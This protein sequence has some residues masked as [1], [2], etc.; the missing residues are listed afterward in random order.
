LQKFKISEKLKEVKVEKRDLQIFGSIWSGIFLVI[1]LY[2]VWSGGELR[3]W[4][5]SIAIL[6]LA[7]SLLKP[8]LL[9]KFY[10][11]WV[12]FGEVIGGFTSKIIMFIIYFGLFTP[13]SLFFKIIGKDPLNRKIDRDSSTYWVERDSQPESMKNQF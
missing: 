10:S 6:F 7:V 12:K 9:E 1:S 8:E 13:V 5:L 2:P 4:S 11:I 3:V